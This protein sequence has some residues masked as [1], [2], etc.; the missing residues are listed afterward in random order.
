MPPAAEGGAL[1]SQDLRTTAD[2]TGLNGAII[3]I[4]PDTGAALAD[5]P[6]YS[7][8]DANTRRIVGYGLRNPFRMVLRP[9]TREMWIGEVGWRDWE[10]L[11]VIPDTLSSS[12]KNFGWPCYEGNGKQAGFDAA[13]LDVCEDLF[14]AAGAVTFPRFQYKEGVAVVAGRFTRPALTRRS[15]AARCSSPTTRGAASG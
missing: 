1:R 11:N 6:M 7:S 9:G 2:R 15:S 5:N 3:R 10:E 4:S 12:I 14:D 8:A 13:N